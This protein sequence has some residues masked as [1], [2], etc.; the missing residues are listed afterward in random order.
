LSRQDTVLRGRQWTLRRVLR[1]QRLPS[2]SPILST[3]RPNLRRLLRCKRLRRSHEDVRPKV[4]PLCTGSLC[5]GRALTNAVFHAD[6]L[7]RARA[8]A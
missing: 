8:S 6:G 4:E 1:R 3:E 5:D 7:D 2:G